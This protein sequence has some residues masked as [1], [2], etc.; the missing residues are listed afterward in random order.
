MLVLASSEADQKAFLDSMGF[1]VPIKDD[2]AEDFSFLVGSMEANGKTAEFGSKQLELITRIDGFFDQKSGG[3]DP[4]FWQIGTP[5][6][7][8]GWEEVRVMAKE[9]LSLGV[10]DEPDIFATQ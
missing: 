2:L 10:T 6:C 9:Y 5:S 4:E 7:D 1:P 8:E 3:A